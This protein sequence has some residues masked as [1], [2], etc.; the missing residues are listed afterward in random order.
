VNELKKRFTPVR[1]QAVQSSLFRDHRQKPNETVD[2]YAQELRTLLYRAYPQVQQE[3]KETE[4]MACTMLANQ[5]A[6][7]LKQEIKVKVAGVEGS[8]EKLLSIAKFEEAKLRDIIHSSSGSR[9][10]ADF[11]KSQDCDWSSQGDSGRFSGRFNRRSRCD[12]SQFN[13]SASSQSPWKCYV[14]SKVG[15]LARECPQKSKAS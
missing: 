2:V 13:S 6:A 1:L 9:K 5:F 8:F 12:G 14:C 10:T 11:S 4:E 3:Q 7:G 15:H